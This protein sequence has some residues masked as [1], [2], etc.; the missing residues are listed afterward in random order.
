MESQLDNIL[1][2][3]ISATSISS[4]LLVWLVEVGHSLLLPTHCICAIVVHYFCRNVY[5]CED[6]H[7]CACG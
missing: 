2:P 6:V 4:C 7:E 3:A 5:T 1:L